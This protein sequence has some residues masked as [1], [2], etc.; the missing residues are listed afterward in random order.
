MSLI[1]R[2]SALQIGGL[3]LLGLT[4][5]KLLAAGEHQPQRA[6]WPKPRAKAAHRA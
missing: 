4:L 5:P 3:G 6:N 1:S 2:R